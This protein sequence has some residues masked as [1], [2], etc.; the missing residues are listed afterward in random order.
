M[1]WTVDNNQLFNMFKLI[2]IQKNLGTKIKK[3]LNICAKLATTPP[4]M[5]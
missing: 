4:Q 1:K 3:A 2:G 5:W